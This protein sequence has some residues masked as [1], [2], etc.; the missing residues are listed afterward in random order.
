MHKT[1]SKQSEAL[2]QSYHGRMKRLRGFVINHPK[3]KL[4]VVKKR[5]V[6]GILL[7]SEVKRFEKKYKWYKV[8]TNSGYVTGKGK[9]RVYHKPTKFVR[10]AYFWNVI[11][12]LTKASRKE[13]KF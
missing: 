6:E 12:I 8:Y 9:K 7:S 3:L 10:Y 5:I 4:P 1:R 11:D 2:S 13:G